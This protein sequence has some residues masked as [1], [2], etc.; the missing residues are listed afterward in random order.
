MTLKHLPTHA[1]LVNPFNGMPL[2]AIGFKRDGSPIWPLM[3]GSQPVGDPPVDPAPTPPAPATDPAPAP[4]PPKHAAP[5]DPANP[6]PADPLG[7]PGKKALTAERDARK[8]ADT[9]RTAAEK[10]NADL[11]AQLDALAPLQKLAAAL[12]GGD[13]DKGKTEVELLSERLAAQEKAIADQKAEVAAERLLRMR[14]EVAAEKGL[15]K[16]Q[17]ARLAGTTA[18]ELAADA[19]ELLALFPAAPATT[20]PPATPP[21]ATPKPA[22]P[23]PDPSQGSRGETPT[24]NTS[25]AGAIATAMAPKTT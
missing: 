25:L 4:A 15:T 8:A 17:A 18:E 12:G 9:A 24:R 3:G 16:A 22:A 21:P 5:H 23:K 10:A 2:T 11:K 1:T 14:L 20:A 7:D 13:A 6:D 19:D